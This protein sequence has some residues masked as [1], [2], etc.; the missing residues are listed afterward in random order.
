M[1]TGLN[2]LT[3]AV[4][5][6]DRSVSFYRDVLRCEL[7]SLRRTGAYFDVGG[8]WLCLSLDSAA[9]NQ[10]R[11]DYTHFA[12]SV[13]AERF[14]EFVAKLSA[15]GVPVWKENTSEGASIYFLDPDGHKLEGHV[16]TLATRL[17]SFERSRADGHSA[18]PAGSACDLD[19][20]PEGP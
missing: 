1:I 14:D 17:A 11:S 13:A 8:F 12:L 7:V 6:L 3:L 19:R 2:H 10:T 16:G 5:D 20:G 9:R 15:H 4:A 18:A